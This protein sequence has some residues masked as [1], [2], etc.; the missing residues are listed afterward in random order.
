M[1]QIRVKKNAGGIAGLC[2]IEPAVHGDARGYFMETYNERDMR[3]AG[4]DVR[5]VQ[6][7]QSMSTKGVL[8]GLHFQKKY[9]QCKLVR[10][11]RGT[12]FDVAVDLRADSETYGK[13]YGVA[14]SAENK[15]QFLIPE[16][17]AH[18]FLVLSDEAEFCYKVSDFWHPNDEGGLAWNDPTIGIDWHVQGEYRGSA[19]ADGCTLADGTPL[20]LSEKDQQWLGL[21]DT[22]KF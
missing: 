10:V 18:G 16:G 2:V 15:K 21:K 6:D 8:R 14:L 7:N 11:V 4:I 20:N 13:W 12:V 19:S 22:F 3:E 17:F 5:F 9:P 1:G